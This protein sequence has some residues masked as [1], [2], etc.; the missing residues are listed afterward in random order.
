MSHLE[1]EDVLWEPLDGFE[2]EALQTETGLALVVFLAEEGN[3]LGL[4]LDG[5]LQN[6][7]RFGEVI[8]VF[9]VVFDHLL[10]VKLRGEVEGR[11]VGR[12][13]EGGGEVGR[14]EGEKEWGVSVSN[15]NISKWERE[16][17]WRVHLAAQ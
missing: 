10:A 12:W 16:R 17:E 7:H 13:E 2:Q 9:A 15:Q 6:V 5:L 4:L 11:E 3:K 8:D 14:W 1:K